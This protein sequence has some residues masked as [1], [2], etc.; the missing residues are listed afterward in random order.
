MVRK[1][2]KDKGRR[3]GSYRRR[4]SKKK[5]SKKSSRRRNKSSKRR[6]KSSKRR[7]KSKSRKKSKNEKKIKM[8]S[9]ERTIKINADG[10]IKLSGTYAIV[11]VDIEH[12]ERI[13]DCAVYISY[14]T[15]VSA[16][17]NIIITQMEEDP[18][19]DKKYDKKEIKEFVLE[20]NSS[21]SYEDDLHGG[22]YRYFISDMM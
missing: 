18:E 4:V 9:S 21:W 10:K 22:N 1:T 16:L 6:N 20:N 11:L 15:A 13:E 12:E 8:V 17:V 14:D 5:S 3:R 7:N 2:R 19:N